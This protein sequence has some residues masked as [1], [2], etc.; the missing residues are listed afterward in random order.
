M[1]KK[2][3]SYYKINKR[4]CIV[5]IRPRHNKRVLLLNWNELHKLNYCTKATS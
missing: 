3:N 4:F 1:K 2:Y 5:D